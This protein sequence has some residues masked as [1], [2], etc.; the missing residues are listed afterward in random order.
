M[1]LGDVLTKTW[2]WEPSVILGCLSLLGGYLAVTDFR[3]QKRWFWFIS[4]DLILLLALISPIHTLG[5][6]YLFS[7]HMLQHLLL[8]LIVPP[9]LLLGFPPKL[10]RRMLK[11]PFLNRAE[12]ILSLPWLAWVLGIGVM[13][14]WHLPVLYEETLADHN[15]H[16]FEHLTFLVTSTIFWWPVITPLQERRLSHGPAMIYLIMAGVASIILG[17][18]ITFAP[19]LYPG[20]TH[21]ADLLG[22]MPTIRN[23]WKISPETDQQVGGLM[24]WVA[25]GPVYLGTIFWVLADWFRSSEETTRREI[26]EEI[27]AKAAAQA[28]KDVVV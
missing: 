8:L 3:P 13:Y 25:S 5:D 22:L 24:M 4:G 27:K 20:Y 1:S 28:N 19:L 6:T 2:N 11:L 21:S 26:E 7:A 9:L 18:V 17:I 14:L 16:I 10:L 23:S 15:V 12:Q